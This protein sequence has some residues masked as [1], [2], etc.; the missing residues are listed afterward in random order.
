MCPRP[1][2]SIEGRADPPGSGFPEFD[3]SSVADP[4]VE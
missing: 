3:A 4:P 1:G 2:K